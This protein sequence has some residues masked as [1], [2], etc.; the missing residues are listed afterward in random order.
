MLFKNN[1]IVE[2]ENNIEFQFYGKW[3]VTFIHSNFYILD[4]GDVSQQFLGENFADYPYNWCGSTESAIISFC[5]N[6]IFD[7]DCEKYLEEHSFLEFNTNNTFKEINEYYSA[8]VIS[9]SLLGC[10]IKKDLKIL[11][12]KIGSFEFTNDSIQLIYKEENFPIFDNELYSENNGF[13]TKGIIR[14]TI[15]KISYSG[16]VDD[17]NYL[18]IG[19]ESLPYKSGD[20][21]YYNLDSIKLNIIEEN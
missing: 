4:P 18:N 15:I 12:E 17:P 8:E 14:D 21:N 3:R 19:Y 7:T 20:F 6:N 13:I 11:R 16:E 1:D 5:E 9:D 10:S 2:E